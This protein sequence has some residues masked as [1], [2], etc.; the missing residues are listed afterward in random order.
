MLALHN[1]Y[2]STIETFED[3]FFE[4]IAFGEDDN[5]DDNISHGKLTKEPNLDLQ[6]TEAEDIL[7]SIG[8]YRDRKSTEEED[9]EHHETPPMNRFWLHDTPGAI[10]D[11]QVYT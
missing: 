2:N 11:A 3:E 6:D 10:N 4:R 5:N 8:L 9:V 1:C 7:R